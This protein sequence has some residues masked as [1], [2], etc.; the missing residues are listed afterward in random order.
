MKERPRFLHHIINCDLLPII[1]VLHPFIFKEIQ[2]RELESKYAKS[3]LFHDNT[4]PIWPTSDH[5]TSLSNSH[6][7]ARAA[8]RPTAP[9]F[10]ALRR[11][12]FA[13]GPRL[14]LVDMPIQEPEYNSLVTNFL[15]PRPHAHIR[16]AYDYGISYANTS[17]NDSNG[18][19]VINVSICGSV[20]RALLHMRAPPQAGGHRGREWILHRPFQKRPDIWETRTRSEEEKPSAFMG[21]ELQN[22]W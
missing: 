21:G 15:Q 1:S 16:V 2:V 11:T 7:L 13:N 14:R 4:A 5:P 12:Q 22:L 17:R 20:G 19:S 9:E 18:S 10:H 8:H 3:A 6:S